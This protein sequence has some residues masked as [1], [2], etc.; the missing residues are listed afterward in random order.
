MLQ[1]ERTADEIV[2]KQ[3]GKI[4]VPTR[5]VYFPYKS[6]LNLCNYTS[7]PLIL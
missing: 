6:P 7:L 3:W 4:S 5:K 2:G 1:K